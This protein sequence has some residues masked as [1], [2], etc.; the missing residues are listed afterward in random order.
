MNESSIKIKLLS[1][2]LRTESEIVLGSEFRYSYG[3][4]RA[5]LFSVSHDRATAYEIKSNRD[6]ISRLEYQLESY[7]KFFDFCYVVCEPSNLKSIRKHIDSSTGII[8]VSDNDVQTVRKSKQFKKLDK[9]LLANTLSTTELRSLSEDKKI[10]SKHALCRQ[11]AKQYTVEQL[12][13]ISREKLHNKYLAGTQILKN[14]AGEIIS[15][16][17]IQTI[18]RPPPSPLVREPQ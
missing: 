8:V 4:R 17:D 10:R 18:S 15:A 13:Q 7:K 9:E 5:D 2:I 14:E 3:S 12:R 16:D 6:N 11:I 1:H